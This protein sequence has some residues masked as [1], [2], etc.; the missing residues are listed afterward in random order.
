MFGHSLLVIKEFIPKFRARLKS[1]MFLHRLIGCLMFFN[2][3]YMTR[4]WT[5]IG[6]T[7]AY[8]EGG[9]TRWTTLL[10]EGKHGLQSQKFSRLGMGVLYLI[11]QV[12]AVFA[13]LAFFNL[14]FLL[15]LVF[16]LPLPAPWRKKFELEAYKVSVIVDQWATGSVSD[17]Y[18]NY[19]AEENFTGWNYYKMWWSSKKIKLELRA[20]AKD[21]FFLTSNI[22]NDP[23][24]MSILNML[25]VNNQLHADGIVSM[26][27]LEIE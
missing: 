2:P 17:N 1:S 25:I 14:W 15:A 13:L 27:R 23:Y 16:L 4:F 20:A 3:A 9:E 24:L 26:R 22:K 6:Y 12:F 11:P 19:I 21:A 8:P 7:A 18:I 10:H 5:T